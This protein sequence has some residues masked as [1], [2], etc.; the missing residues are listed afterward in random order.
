MTPSKNTHINVLVVTWNSGVELYAA[1]N[2]IRIACDK[3]RQRYQSSALS[4]TY[5]ILV[6][7]NS[8]TD[9]S[10]NE[11]TDA[12]DLHLIRHKK[13]IGFAAANNALAM[14]CESEDWLWLVNPDTI[15]DPNALLELMK[16]SDDYP[17]FA[18]FGS[19][20]VNSSQREKLDGLGDVVH[21]SG[22]AWRDGFGQIAVAE[23]SF[24]KPYECFAVCGAAL[25]IRKAD[26]D[27]V[28][29]FDEAFFCYQEDVDFGFRLRLMRN[30]ALQIPSAVV[31]HVGSHSTGGHQSDFSVYHGRRN[32]VWCYIKNMPSVLFW[33][34]L[35]LHLALNF[36]DIIYFT[37]RGQGRVI[38]SAKWNAVKNL[39]NI[40]RKRKLIQ[41]QRS[42]T[43]WDIWRALDKRIW[44]WGFKSIRAKSSRRFDGD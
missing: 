1:L 22:L 26:F 3:A 19:T 17:G 40:L 14:M 32:L 33:L 43:S 11:L 25:F 38:W 37:Y 34:C 2:A 8:S 24:A 18:C 27:A 12:T 7:D 31:Y 44:P 5:E 42:A 20:L 10:I 28:G 41:S 35:P 16:A 23:K 6:W 39:P 36:L 29:G 15:A 9:A 30:R 13:N 21:I 4:M